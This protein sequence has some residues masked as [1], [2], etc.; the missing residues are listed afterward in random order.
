MA[1]SRGYIDDVIVPSETRKRV[2]AAFDTLDGKR[3]NRHPR[4]HGNIPL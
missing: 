1:A 3:A 4:K 2:I